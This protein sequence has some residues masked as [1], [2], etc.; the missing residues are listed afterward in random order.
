MPHQY[1]LYQL[2]EAGLNQLADH[3]EPLL[4]QVYTKG[5][6]DI[7]RWQAALD[8][9][10]TP[11]IDSR[12]LIDRVTANGDSLTEHHAALMEFHPWR[13][14]PYSLHGTEIDT[15]WR[16][17]WKWDRVAPHIS[18][19]AGRRVLDVGCGN[20]YHGWR[21][22][23]AGATQVLGI[24]P[25][26]LFVMQFRTVKKL[27]GYDKQCPLDVLPLGIEVL[28]ANSQAFDTVFSMGV[29]YHRRSPLSH[30]IELRDLLIPG[31]E[32]V[33][34]TLVVE[35]EL[36]Y[37]LLPQGAG[38]NRYAQMRNTW[39]LPSIATLEL[40]LRRA[41]F[42]DIRTVDDSFTTADEQRSTDWMTFQSLPDF[43][44][45]MDSSKTIEGYP[46]PRRATLVAQ[47]PS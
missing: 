10:P 33:L 11:Q 14:G 13:K 3:I 30:L 37:C 20:G 19:L 29:L 8:S 27:L 45:P 25:T 6:G 38:G 17:D 4:T 21:M 16:S 32:L 22:L 18:N 1:A 7:P 42:D 46:A 31:G 43:L 44:D 40:W 24:D 15:E 26:M 39:F 28:P 5:H 35:G 12:N 2:R 36:G 47:R 23:G 9:L 34:E 41:G